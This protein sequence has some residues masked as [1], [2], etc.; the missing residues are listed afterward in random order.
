MTV[1]GQ[2]VDALVGREPPPAADALP[3]APDRDAVVGLSGIDDLVV[4]L[5]AV[6][7]AHVATVA[8][9][10]SRLP[11]ESA[12]P[13][14]GLADQQRTVVARLAS[15]RRPPGAGP[16]SGPRVGRRSRASRRAARRIGPPTG[17]AREPRGVSS[18]APRPPDPPRAPGP[19]R[20]AGRRDA[21]ASTWWSRPAADARVPAVGIGTK[22]RWTG[23][24][25]S[26]AG[27][28]RSDLGVFMTAAIWFLHLLR[29]CC[30]LLRACC[31]LLRAC[32]GA[33][34]RGGK[35]QRSVAAGSALLVLIEP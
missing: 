19:P 14:D 26:A 33:K 3:P 11:A 5:A 31:G 9:S 10:P 23:R 35:D 17:G 6:G 16:R 2:R 28:L 7:T 27:Y 29:A 13:D 1:S 22:V 12:R 4:D 18:R 21:G 24:W 32:C 34:L 20:P 30:G 8:P 25:S 15:A